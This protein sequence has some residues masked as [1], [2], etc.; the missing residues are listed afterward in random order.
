[1]RKRTTRILA[2]TLCLLLALTGAAAASNE[3]ILSID[4]VPI[5]GSPFTADTLNGVS[6]LYGSSEYDCTELVRRYYKT[7]YGVDVLFYDSGLRVK[8]NDTYWFEKTDT[9]AP[10]DVLYATGTARGKSYAHAALLKFLSDGGTRATLIEQNWSWNNQAAYEREIPWPSDCYTAYTLRCSSGVPTP[11]LQQA[12]TVSDWAESL[13]A[14]AKTLGLTAEIPDGWQKAVT[15]ERLAYLLVAADHVLTG[16]TAAI[17]DASA[18]ADSLGLLSAGSAK[19]TVTR[20][21]AA[22]ALTRLIRLAGKTPDVDKTALELYPDA[23]EISDWAR[24]GVAVMTETGLMNGTEEGFEPA[25]TLTTEQAAALAVRICENPEPANVLLIA[26]SKTVVL[27]RG[28]LDAF[29]E[30][31]QAAEASRARSAGELIATNSA[32]NAMIG[33]SH[34]NG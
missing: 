22:V 11:K 9:P 8:D 34:T 7:L 31:E 25:G 24:E 18:E 10:G 32:V 14:E 21:A 19:S 26:Q 15:R 3:T 27:S 6:A 23:D 29:D 16:N 4:F 13:V 28:S 20:E 1:M 2:L 30:I 12:D 17:T 33:L 5:T